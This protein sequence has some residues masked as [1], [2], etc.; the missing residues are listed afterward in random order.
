MSD[1]ILIEYKVG[2]AELMASSKVLQDELRKTESVGVEGAKKVTEEFDK[3]AKKTKS[4]AAQLKELKNEIGKATDP[5]EATRLAE[6]AAKIEKQLRGVNKQV[7]Q[8]TQSKFQNIT[9]SFGEVGQKMAKLDFAGALKS[10][11][12]F[13]ESVKAVTF[14][15]SLGGL[16]NLGATILSVGKTMLS[17]PIFL[18]GGAIIA[19]IANFDKLKNAGGAVGK[20]F[21]FIGEIISGVVHGFEDM[22]N[23]LGLVDTESQKI[24]ESQKKNLDELANAHAKTSDRIIKILKAQGKETTKFEQQVLDKKIQFVEQEYNDYRDM[25]YDKGTTLDNVSEEELKKLKELGDKK[26]DLVAELMAVYSAGEVARV[27][28]TKE[29]NDRLIKEAE[30]LAKLLRDLQTNNIR[31]DYERKRQQILNNFDDE[32]AKHK[33]HHAVLRELEIKKNNELNDL[34][35]ERERHYQKILEDGRDKSI[36]IFKK[37]AEEMK[38]EDVGLSTTFINNQKKITERTKQEIA[39]REQAQQ[40]AQQAIVQFIGDAA[41]AISQIHQNQI[42]AEIQGVNESH[43]N[44]ISRLDKQLAHKVITQEQYNL[45]KEALDKQAHE[46]EKALKIKAFEAQKQA[47][48]ISTLI[49]TATAIVAQLANPTPYVGFVLAAL[50]AATGA[51]QIA[52]IESQPTPKFAKGVVGLKGKGTGTSDE[53][54]AMLSKGESV[55][56]SS[57]SA[58]YNGLLSAMNK[59]QTANFIKEFYIAPALKAQKQKFDNNKE[60]SFAQSLM[61][62]MNVNFKDHNLLDSLKQSRKS[63]RE[64]FLFL[65]KEIK[66]N[67]SGNARR[68]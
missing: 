8:F 47:S 15:E 4:L 12:Q 24:Y 48:I 33:G 18:I 30:D 1:V 57:E 52:V 55:V 10:S 61:R 7:E 5:K 26:A 68:W 19:I 13:S 17:S 54:P 37:G 39:E 67:G 16:K 35:A 65:V 64:N 45:K 42:A 60:S 27:K 51:A 46:K 44:E 25:L 58:K 6:A 28:K 56:I 59:G 3:T 43:D 29:T 2:T 63:E 31:Y 11:K 66:N 36:E 53:I 41:N 34:A 62:S 40:Q 50:A 14:K 22:L 49:N 21:S 32:A 23:F 38:A 20:V 9:S